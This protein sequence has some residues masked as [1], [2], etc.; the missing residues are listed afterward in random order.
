MSKTMTLEVSDNLLIE[1]DFFLVTR[2]KTWQATVTR[3]EKRILIDDKGGREYCC[4]CVIGPDTR[5]CQGPYIVE[6]VVS[7]IQE[8]AF[9]GEHDPI[10]FSRSATWDAFYPLV[11]A[12]YSAAQMAEGRASV[13]GKRK[14]L[15]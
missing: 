11:S 12:Q 15:S 10:D 14:S 8:L 1:I 9:G 7:T 13:R 5:S 2:T 4:S 3:Y 6:D